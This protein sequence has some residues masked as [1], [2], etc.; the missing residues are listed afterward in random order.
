MIIYYIYSKLE[1]NYLLIIIN[2]FDLNDIKIYLFRENYTKVITYI[3]YKTNINMFYLE[4]S[5]FKFIKIFSKNN[6]IHK[7]LYRNMS[8]LTVYKNNMHYTKYR[9]NTN[10]MY[11]LILNNKVFLLKMPLYK[12]I[13]CFK[14][15]K[16]EIN[17]Y[18]NFFST[19]TIYK[20]LI[21]FI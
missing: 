9:K 4:S 16:H 12:L 15:F 1:F 5:N 7:L 17:L 2:I 19:F 14:A 10:N 20:Y 11:Y 8:E 6:I 13:S 21:L 3:N 18:N